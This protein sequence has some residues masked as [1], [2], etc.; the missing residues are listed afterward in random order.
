MRRDG[1]GTA[2]LRV[3]RTFGRTEVLCFLPSQFDH[4][5]L[6]STLRRGR[7]SPVLE[8]SG[9]ALLRWGADIRVTRMVMLGQKKSHPCD[10]ER[11]VCVLRSTLYLFAL[12]SRHGGA[13]VHGTCLPYI[14]FH[15]VLDAVLQ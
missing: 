14:C 13:T 4:N 6:G 2:H 10:R 12:R 3:A 9:I 8:E 5:A 7:L 11:G 15:G 1:P